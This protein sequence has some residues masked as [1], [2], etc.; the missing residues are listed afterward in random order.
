MYSAPIIAVP[1][2]SPIHGPG[3]VQCDDSSDDDEERGIYKVKFGADDT[4]NLGIKF[5]EVSIESVK[6]EG[7][8]QYRARRTLEPGFV[9]KAINGVPADRLAYNAI[10]ELVGEYGGDIRGLTLS[11]QSME[12]PGGNF[13]GFD[14]R[15]G[16]IQGGGSSI[17]DQERIQELE[18]DVTELREELDKSREE[19]K[20]AEAQRD[21]QETVVIDTLAPLLPRATAL[22]NYPANPDDFQDGDLQFEKGERIVLLDLSDDE[23][24]RGYVEN[25]PEEVGDFPRSFIEITGHTTGVG[26][27]AEA[28]SSESESDKKLI[29][30]LQKMVKAL[31]AQVDAPTAGFSGG[32]GEAADE[33]RRLQQENAGLRAQMEATEQDAD[34]ASQRAKSAESSLAEADGGS[35]AATLQTTKDELRREKK[36][37]NKLQKRAIKDQKIIK[38]LDGDKKFLLER[39]RDVKRELQANMGDLAHMQAMVNRLREEFAQTIPSVERM[40]CERAEEEIMRLNTQIDDIVEQKVEDI[41]RELMVELDEMTEKYRAECVLRRKVFNELQDLKG[42]IRVFCRTRPL[43]PKEISAREQLACFF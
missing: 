35:L 4:G 23:W 14:D 7:M 24:G 30:K 15:P 43:I 18:A 40:V 10:S 29:K 21:E 41:R 42:N 36:L 11:F 3:P 9:L 26:S 33:I 20:T 16:A 13:N 25:K 38:A 32:H 6:P 5:R 8:G 19:T 27:A 39:F 22:H 2:A 31:Q 17:A 12:K 34:E 1:G 28:V 37:R